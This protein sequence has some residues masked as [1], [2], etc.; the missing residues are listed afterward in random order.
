MLVFCVASL[1]VLCHSLVVAFPGGFILTYLSRMGF[2]TIINWASLF[3]YQGLLGGILL[4]Y[5]N[6]NRTFCKQTAETLIRRRVLRRL[7]L[8]CTV[9]LCPTK[10]TLGLYGLK[11]ESHVIHYTYQNPLYETTIM[12]FTFLHGDV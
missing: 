5:S 7:I 11:K 2:P 1:N 12:H 9:C 10:R 6:F 4:L 8:V 3:P